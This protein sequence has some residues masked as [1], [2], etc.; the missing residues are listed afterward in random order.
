MKKEMTTE[1]KE[2]YNDLKMLVKRANQR[3]VR[4]ERLTGEKDSFSAKQLFDYL[5]SEKLKAVTKSNRIKINNF[6]LEQMQAIKNA[7]ENFLDKDS[8][9]TVSNI[10]KYK[11][12]V[13]KAIGTEVSFKDLSAIYKARDLWKWTEEQ[14]GS[15]FWTDFA[16]RILEQSKNEWIEFAKLYS[17]EGN[18][19]EL[20]GKLSQIYDYIQKHGI[21]GAINFD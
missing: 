2:L 4:L 15:A 6:N 8:L 5:S 21:K 14:Y 11:A 18:D 13:E 1:E 17:Q 20:Q 9:S 7:V 3:L 10:K 12:K 16:P 19:L